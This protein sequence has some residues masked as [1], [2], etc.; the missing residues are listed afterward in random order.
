MLHV[1]N[2]ALITVLQF[3]QFSQRRR[4]SVVERRASDR[5]NAFYFLV[6]YHAFLLHTLDCLQQRATSVFVK[7]KITMKK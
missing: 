3:D 2:N 7:K 1:N 4:C 5:D 6:T